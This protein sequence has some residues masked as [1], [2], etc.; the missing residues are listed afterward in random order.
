MIN[1]GWVEPF[2]KA[3]VLWII[4][5]GAAAL[6][7]VHFLCDWAIKQLQASGVKYTPATFVNP[8]GTVVQ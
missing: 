5:G 8:D 3:D 6:V 7:G 4:V 1:P 2:E